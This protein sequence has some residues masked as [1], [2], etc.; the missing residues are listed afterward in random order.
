ME[1]ETL[2]K[3]SPQEVQAISAQIDLKVLREWMRG[4]T[5]PEKDA[6]TVASAVVDPQNQQSFYL[7]ETGNMPGYTEYTVEDD[8]Y[9]DG[10]DFR[11]YVTFY[12]VSVGVK[13]KGAV[14]ICP[15]G[16]FVLR[17]WPIEGE[18]VA[19]GLNAL[20]YQCFVVGYRCDP[21][22]QE[23]RGYDLARA[24][25][26][27]RK[28]AEA[29]GINPNHISVVGFSAGGI[30]CGE[31][32]QNCAGQINGSKID[33]NY[34]PDALDEISADAAVAGMGYSFYGI[35]SHASVDVEKLR[36][37]VLP[38]TF[39]FHGSEEAFYNEITRNIEAVT[40][41]GAITK[42]FV[43]DGQKHGFGGL[44][45]EWFAEFDAFMMKHFD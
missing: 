38:P 2:K 34:V 35:L 45:T 18:P 30:L 25:R 8:Q 36:A 32:L 24:I 39:Y 1:L 41:A 23:E 44:E 17:A 29:Y 14:I 28:N 9:L 37:S 21:W 40:A 15:G 19:K 5:S 22:T 7:W 12:P 43:L 20:G 11:P 33:P 42:R 4:D 26:F 27:V 13:V 3:M 6:L 10:P 31:L 16:A